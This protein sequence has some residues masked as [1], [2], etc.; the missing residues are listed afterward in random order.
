MAFVGQLKQNGVLS[1]LYNMIIGQEVFSDNIELKGTLFEKFRVDG[2]LYGD[3]KLFIS[4]D[5]G[6]VRDFPDAVEHY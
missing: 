1:S 3:T 4:T 5:V 2:T 6:K